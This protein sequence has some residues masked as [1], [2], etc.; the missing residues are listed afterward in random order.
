M[1]RVLERTGGGLEAEGDVTRLV[2]GEKGGLGGCVGRAIAGRGGLPTGCC[3]RGDLGGAPGG[4]P[5]ERTCPSYDFVFAELRL[6]DVF[7]KS[8]EMAERLDIAPDDTKAGLTSAPPSFPEATRTEKRIARQT[9]LVHGTRGR[10]GRQE[11]QPQMMV[12]Q[13]KDSKP[14]SFHPSAFKPIKS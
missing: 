6:A 1:G 4:S 10:G 9:Q 12:N 5:G 7:T 2:P 11:S 14:S 13:R 3:R 8:D